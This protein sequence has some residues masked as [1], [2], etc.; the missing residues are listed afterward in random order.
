MSH[1]CKRPF[2]ASKQ[3]S[4]TRMLL[5]YIDLFIR[6]SAAS[7][8]AT[9]SVGKFPQ[10]ALARGWRQAGLSAFE[11]ATALALVIPMSAPYGT[12]VA[13]ALFI[14]FSVYV[15]R[16]WRSGKTGDCGCGG[17]LPLGAIGR[18]H[19]VVNLCLAVACLV[20]LGIGLSTADELAIS[21][22][23]AGALVGVWLPLA[24]LLALRVATT[25]IGTHGQLRHLDQL[26]WRS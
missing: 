22:W 20:S 14:C 16:L 2:T 17:L 26:A 23:P 6:G 18:T 5:D 12:I 4:E 8:L 7:I 1:A 19:I 3:I 24:T 9:A 10:A 13:A 15:G 21:E 25:L 11:M